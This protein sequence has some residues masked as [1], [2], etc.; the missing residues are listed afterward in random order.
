MFAVKDVLWT[1]A[2]NL[3]GFVVRGAAGAMLIT[4][5]DST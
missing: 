2:A 1:F 3:C 5:P 4:A